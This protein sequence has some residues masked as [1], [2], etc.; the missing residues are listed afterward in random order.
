M[1]NY[2]STIGKLI[3]KQEVCF[4]SFIDAK[5]FPTTRTMLNPRK[6]QGLKEFYLTTNRR[7]NKVA[8]LLANPKA[9]LYFMT[10]HYIVE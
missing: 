4:L 7:S 2:E 3:D 9:G 8:A 1:E 10:G 6:R 5:G